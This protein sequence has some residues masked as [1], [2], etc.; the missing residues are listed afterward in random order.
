[1]IFSFPS[2]AT[3]CGR[4]DWATQLS[5]W[6]MLRRIF[7]VA[8]GFSL[9][10][11]I[12]AASL[13]LLIGLYDLSVPFSWFGSRWELAC[14]GG[15]VCLDNQPEVDAPALARKQLEESIAARRA[16]LEKILRRAAWRSPAYML[17][18]QDLRKLQATSAEQRRQLEIAPPPPSLIEHS[19]SL[20][21]I[22][23]LS[24][25]L[26]AICLLWTPPLFLQRAARQLRKFRPP[27]RRPITWP[28]VT[29]A[30]LCCIVGL[31]WLKSRGHYASVSFKSQRQY[32]EL[33]IYDGVLGG[34]WARNGVQYTH[35]QDDPTGVRFKALDEELGEVRQF[36]SGQS[37]F[38]VAAIGINPGEY[39]R[40]ESIHSISTPPWLPMVLFAI[41]PAFW[42][43]GSVVCLLRAGRLKEGKCYRC[44]YDLRASP[45]YCPECG[46]TR[47]KPAMNPGV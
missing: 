14:R 26:A 46:A 40:V 25:I 24:A 15:V 45:L 5:C 4:R 1:M 47:L 6:R 36:R 29:S 38:M 20:Y 28:V 7:I 16:A 21:L 11:F 35:G 27:Y 2:R 32:V 10:V 22:I 44:G 39:D 42:L 34:T 33:F 31:L 9:A 23:L 37:P 8:G 43:V 17:A 13:W 41:L 19:A 30:A 12:L 18:L 3:N